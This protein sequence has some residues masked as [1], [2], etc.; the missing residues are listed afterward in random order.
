MV[1]HSICLT[2]LD[3]LDELKEI[4]VA[5]AYELDGV[6]LSSIPS[7]Q[8]DLGRIV[9]KYDTLPGWEK[10]TTVC[11]DHAHVCPVHSDDSSR[12]SASLKTCP[13]MRKLTSSTF[14]IQ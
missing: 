2:K 5:T 8:E 11:H 10:D 13:K 12:L 1:V 7:T 3:V 9:V 4:K 14:K 6:L